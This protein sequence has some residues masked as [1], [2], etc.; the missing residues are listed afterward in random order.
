MDVDQALGGLPPQKFL[1][2]VDRLF[3]G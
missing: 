3:A 2:A 1:T